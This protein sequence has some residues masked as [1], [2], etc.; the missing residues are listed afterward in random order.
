[1]VTQPLVAVYFSGLRVKNYRYRA[2]ISYSH[3]DERW[4]DWLQ[5]ALESY[6][7]PEAL[8]G[9]ETPLGP[10]P[11]RL[12]PIFRDRDDFPAAGN[13]NNAIQEALAESRFQIVICSPNA[14]K[15]RWVN[16][17]IKLFKRLHG[18]D[19]TLAVIVAGEP[20]ASAIQGREEE[21]CFPPGLRFRV[22][23]NGALTGEPAEP[24]AADA[25]AEGDG[26]RQAVTKLA[27]GLLGVS[28]DDLVQREAAR[29]A[30][31]ARRV[32]AGS[33][34][35][36]GAMAALTV[37]AVSARRD[38]QT[39]RGHAE[40]LI[41]FMLTDLRDRLEPVGKLD[42]LQSVGEK[43]LDYYGQQNL[44]RLDGDTLNRRA[45]A[46][47]LVGNIHQR[48]NDLGAALEAYEAAAATTKEQLR[49]APDDPQRIFDHAQAVFYVGYIATERGDL[50]A[51]GERFQ[52]YYRLAQRLVAIDPDNP[53]WR[54]EVAYATSNLGSVKLNAGDYDA[55]APFFEETVAIR[56][57]L[58][59][60][61]PDDEKLAYA[62]AYALSWLA[63]NDLLR[64]HYADTIAAIAEQISLYDPMLR[65]NPENF[66]VLNDLVLA[67]RRLG[68]A[69]L[70]LGN[71][72][73]ARTALSTAMEMADRLLV[74]EPDEAR[75]AAIA[76]YVEADLSLLLEFE[77]D[78]QG[79]VA[80]SSKA[81][82]LASAL[83]A[84]GSDL[85]NVRSAL[86]FALV[87]RVATGG[88]MEGREQ[89][90]LELA[91]LLGET[92]ADPAPR[93]FGLIGEAALTLA[94]FEAERSGSEK[95]LNYVD[96]GV[97]QLSSNENKLSALSRMALAGLYLE[98]GDAE[99]AWRICAG[100]DKLGLRRPDYVKFKKRLQSIGE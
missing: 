1:M 20:G 26:R 54:L 11:R 84:G 13:L 91:A 6:R 67:R 42:V 61:A 8:V 77:G 5:R 73:S 78:F 28:L 97:S 45:R 63:Y 38:A 58:H 71:L 39:M 35:I 44:K 32:M 79:A 16:E 76:V 19:R 41:E 43:A 27:A 12:S 37:T 94:R 75:W 10:A 49:R 66:T 74:W 68:E 88:E 87:R 56:R 90:A 29:R 14:A 83:H 62:F 3:A 48:R 23:E 81:V 64:G 15:S 33:A 98:A 59:E 18:Q 47:L 22:D 100:L 24:I 96:L 72:A 57:A 46:L 65:K 40:N 82:S 21:E 52:D 7:V 2:F 85:A 92:A 4:G 25:R 50:A 93:E 31:W 99:S 89:A 80:A 69:Y 86:G 30:R 60:A 70:A 95:A 51:A 36:V 9:K 34:A 53:D 17:E 55:A